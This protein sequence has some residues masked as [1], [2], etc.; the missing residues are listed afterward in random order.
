MDDVTEQR[1]TTHAAW[2]A[3][4]HRNM[5]WGDIFDL[6]DRIEPGCRPHFISL[7]CRQLSAANLQLFTCLLHA[8]DG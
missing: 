7:V 3:R 1:L 6:L 4:E 5:E 8:Y 2:I